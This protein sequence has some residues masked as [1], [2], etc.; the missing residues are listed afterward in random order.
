MIEVT[1]YRSAMDQSQDAEV[2]AE[3]EM[4]AE[5]E[6]NN[7]IDFELLDSL[8]I[9]PHAQDE[10]RRQQGEEEEEEEEEEEMDEEG[11]NEEDSRKDSEDSLE[12]TY[13]TDGNIYKINSDGTLTLLSEAR[14]TDTANSLKSDL[15]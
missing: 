12:V 15:E 6:P 9:N 3:G 2:E 11:E 1:D 14:A 5:L 8:L 4:E 10:R 7:D 13:G